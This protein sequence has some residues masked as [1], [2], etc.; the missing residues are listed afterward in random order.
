MSMEKL[1]NVQNLSVS[2]ITSKGTIKAV[3]KISFGV[4]SGKSVSIVGESGCG[5]ST[6]ARSVI[7]LIPRPGRITGGSIL[8]R[9]RNLL[10]LDEQEMRSVRGSQISM[11]FQDPFSYLNPVMKIG[12]Q[13]AQPIKSHQNV[14]KRDIPR[15]VVKV[16]ESVKIPSAEKVASYYPHQLSGGMAQRVLI[17]MA[18]SCN[19]SLLI[20]DEPTTALDVSVQAQI[21]KLIKEYRDKTGMSLLLITHNLGI[22]ADISDWIYI[23]YC[24]KIVESADIAQIYVNPKHPYTIGLLNSIPRIDIPKK[25]FLTIQGIVPDLINPPSG[26]RFHPR[27]PHAKAICAEKEPIAA[28]IEEGHTVFCWLFS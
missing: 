20:A 12:D 13:V 23:M 10:D 18:I 19:P 16:L 15:L 11:V 8:F 7:R 27:C 5:K 9:D 17:G 14:E 26:C 28:E 3:D 6:I 24:G 25:R 22:T 1:L 2:Y 21:L 4:G